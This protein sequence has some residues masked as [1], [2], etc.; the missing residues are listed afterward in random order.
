[1]W[2]SCTTAPLLVLSFNLNAIYSSPH[3][4]HSSHI[5]FFCSSS[6]S[7]SLLFHSS[8]RSSQGWHI[9]AIQIS[10]DIL[11]FSEGF[12]GYL[13]KTITNLYHI[14]CLNYLYRTNHKFFICF[15][16]VL[17]PFRMQ[18]SWEQEQLLSCSSLYSQYLK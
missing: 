13:I 8:L 11:F 5:C 12:S 10:N 1:M 7:W 4:L 2:L 6:I 14:I 17:P 15:L 18:P 9:L 16:I 3:L